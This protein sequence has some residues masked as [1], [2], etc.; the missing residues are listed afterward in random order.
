MGVLPHSELNYEDMIKVLEKIHVYVPSKDVEREFKIPSEEG[1]E[2]VIKVDDKKFST[3]LVG[4]DQLTAAWC[5][6]DTW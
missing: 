5:T 4:G 6:N 2:S 3:L 1:S